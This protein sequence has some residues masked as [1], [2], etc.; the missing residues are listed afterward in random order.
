MLTPSALRSFRRCGIIALAIASCG[1]SASPTHASGGTLQFHATVTGKGHDTGGFSR[2]THS[3]PAGQPLLALLFVGCAVVKQESG[4]GPATYE[5]LVRSTGEFVPGMKPA[6]PGVNLTIDNFHPN[7]RSA[8]YAGFDV[9]GTFA[10]NG[11]AY[12]GASNAEKSAARVSK[13]GLNGTWTDTAAVRIYP[14]KGGET[15]PGFQYHAT[16]HCTSL[17]HI[18]QK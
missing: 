16:W 7:A 9:D 10:I 15:V 13:G 14:A 18:T 1:V 11:H 4:G 17:F 8:T 5:L 3:A 12:G 6:Q 2:A